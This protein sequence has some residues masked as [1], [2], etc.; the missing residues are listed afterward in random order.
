MTDSIFD[1]SKIKILIVDDTPANIEV[2]H[3]TLEPEGYLISIAT[4]GKMALEITHHLEPDLILLDI[5]MPEI[6]GFE[7][8]QRLKE[9]ECTRDIPVI[10]I[11]AK[12]EV[13]DIVEGFSLGGVDYIIKPI[14][15][16]EVLSRVKTHVQLN[17]FKKQQERRIQELECQNRKLEKLDEIKNRFLGTAMHDLRNPLSS[18]RG[19]SELFLREEGTYS[20]DEKNE[21]VKM[22]NSASKDLLELVSDLLDVSVLESGQLNLNL[23]SGNLNPLLLKQVQMNQVSASQKNIKIATSLEEVSDSIFDPNRM[24]QVMAN[25]ISNAIKFSQPGTTIQVGLSRNDESLE[26]YVKD[27]GPGIPKEDR[28]RLFTEFPKINVYPT[29]DEKSI[30]LGLAI[31]QKI[32]DAHSGA[33]HVDS[34]EGQGTTFY[35]ELPLEVDLTVRGTGFSVSEQDLALK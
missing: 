29:G 18:I 2:L 23:S 27:E 4:N 14:R 31:V 32:V 13:K 9:N 7:A 12:G 22:I 26:F 19:F 8:C 35:V 21:L 3:K 24:G 11:S 33:V 25:L 20:E 17:Y 28:C 15:R 34:E 30:G 1:P 6:D 5:M 10:F 16:E